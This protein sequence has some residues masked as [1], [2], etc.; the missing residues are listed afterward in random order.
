VRTQGKDGHVQAK[1]R[2]VG[3]NQ[4]CRPLDLELPGSR[5]QI[6]VV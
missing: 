4:P 6:F 2:D 3:R 5:K 1:Q